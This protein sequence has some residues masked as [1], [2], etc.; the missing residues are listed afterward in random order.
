MIFYK[1]ALDTV[2]HQ[3]RKLPR[4]SGVV[5]P[6]RRHRASQHG[7]VTILMLQPFAIQSRPAGGT[8]EQKAFGHHV[9]C[10]PD[11]VT[12]TLK[13]EHRIED[14]KRNS[15]DAEGSVGRT[16]SD[17]RGNRP[18]LADAFL[19]NLSVNRFAIA[20]QGLCIDRCVTL[21]VRGIN[22]RH[23]EQRIHPKGSRLVRHDWH[24]Q[25]SDFGVFQQL[26][27]QSHHGC[28]RR[29]RPRIRARIKCLE[30]RRIRWVKIRRENLPRRQIAA[31]CLAALS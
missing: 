18:S 30:N 6:H 2:T 21:S 11:Q 19:Q 14:I 24:D 3:H 20:V 13:T 17:K 8:T 25:R 5:G 27:Q 28:G 23:F 7:R 31:Q 29:Q 4:E 9:S 26:G 10:R 15:A 12:D 22:A 16:R 1:H